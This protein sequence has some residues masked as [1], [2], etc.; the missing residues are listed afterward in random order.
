MIIIHQQLEQQANHTCEARLL[1]V[2]KPNRESEPL[3]LAPDRIHTRSNDFP[4][5]TLPTS[6]IIQVYN[7]TPKPKSQ[8][9]QIPG[10]VKYIS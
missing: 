8:I 2:L 5:S 1:R 4:S 3:D 6:Y 7:T 9:L 10:K